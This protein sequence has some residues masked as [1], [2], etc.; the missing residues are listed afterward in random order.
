M[1]LGLKRANDARFLG[2]GDLREDRNRCGEIRQCGV[3]HLFDFGA[4]RDAVHLE[5][6]L[7]A[8]LAGDNL[9]V[10]GENLDRDARLIERGDG[11][12]GAFLRRVEK[13][14]VAEQRQTGL[15]IDR[16]AWL[17]MGDFLVGDCDDA[18]PVLIERPS[19]RLRLGEMVRVQ[20]SQLI[21]QFVMLTG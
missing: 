21:V 3:A 14:D 9:I 1:A 19:L 15:V 17:G 18:E 11:G 12:A 4:E 8:D 7:A 6:N 13:G 16:I 10:A 2:R 5:A 20:S